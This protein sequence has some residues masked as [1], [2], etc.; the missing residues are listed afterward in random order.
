MSKPRV[1][2][3]PAGTIKSGDRIFVKIKGGRWSSAPWY[4]TNTERWALCF[5]VFVLHPT[6][7]KLGAQRVPFNSKDK[8]VPKVVK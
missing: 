6:N 5:N 1:K 2:M 3:V 8:L 7:Y 4:V